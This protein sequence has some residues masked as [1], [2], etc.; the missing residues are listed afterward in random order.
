MYSEWFYVRDWGRVS[1]ID[2]IAFHFSHSCC[3]SVFWGRDFAH[4]HIDRQPNMFFHFTPNWKVCI[5]NRRRWWFTIFVNLTW[6]L[7]LQIVSTNSNKLKSHILSG[8][9]EILF[10]FLIDNSFKFAYGWMNEWKVC[11]CA[12]ER[13]CWIYKTILIWTIPFW[14]AWLT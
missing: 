9:T 4:R 14:F 2:L 6:T 11:V 7:F 10:E 5:M 3:S 12:F 13:M 1:C 8:F